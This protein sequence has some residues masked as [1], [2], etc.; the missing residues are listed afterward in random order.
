MAPKKIIS[1]VLAA[2]TLHNFLLKSKT[3]Y[4]TASTFDKYTC[5]SADFQRG[6]WRGHSVDLNSLQ[7]ITIKNVCTE[8]KRNRED[9]INYFNS[10]DGQVEWQDR[11][12]KKGKA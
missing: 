6:E 2:C 11:I 8:T 4:A 3:A 1:T 10:E 9:Y 12:I 7:S 5:N